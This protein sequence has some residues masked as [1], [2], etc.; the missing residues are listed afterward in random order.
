MTYPYTLLFETNTIHNLQSCF[1]TF[2]IIRLEYFIPH[3]RYLRILID[4]HRGTHKR[5]T[6]VYDRHGESRE[7]HGLYGLHSLHGHSASH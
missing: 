5:H 4:W 2:R 3:I 1:L 7:L 6:G